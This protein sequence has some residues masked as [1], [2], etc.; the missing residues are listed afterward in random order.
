LL[1][2]FV[3]S[4]QG[5]KFWLWPMLLAIHLPDAVFIWL[6]AAQ[7]QNLF[8]IGAGVV[9]EQ[10]GYGFGFTAF[11][12]YMIYVARG[13]HSTAHYALC[14]G[15]MAL[16]MNLP[17]LWSGWLQQQLG[18]KLFFIW[19]ILATVPSFIAAAKIPLEA[20]FGKKTQSSSS[21]C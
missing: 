6:A 19:V 3:V 10:F 9:V 4:R 18:Y 13:P 7:P 16:G 2:G 15:F 1:G 14:T 12:L 17:N 8:A 21:S 5:L 11:M 20:E